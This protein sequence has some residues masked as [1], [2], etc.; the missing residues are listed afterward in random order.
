MKRNKEIARFLKGIGYDL[1]EIN[2]IFSNK[3][4]YEDAQK[5][6]EAYLLMDNNKKINIEEEQKTR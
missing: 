5:Y 1:R 6:Y 2:Y 3:K 4:S